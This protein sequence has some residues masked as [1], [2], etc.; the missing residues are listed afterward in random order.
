MSV[1][2]ARLHCATVFL[3]AA[4]LDHRTSTAIFRADRIQQCVHTVRNPRDVSQL[5][6]RD[7]GLA[8]LSRFCGLQQL[9]DPDPLYRM[10]EPGRERKGKEKHCYQST[11]HS[12]YGPVLE[13]HKLTSQCYV[14][15]FCQDTN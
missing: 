6:Q 4:K 8:K 3:G 15:E 5:L 12:G 1:R 10:F 11:R 2:S 14:P 9:R 7:G 13:I